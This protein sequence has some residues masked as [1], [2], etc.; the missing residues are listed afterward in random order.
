M[1]GLHRLRHRKKGWIEGLHRLGHTDELCQ[2]P[3]KNLQV[4]GRASYSETL[5][6][7]GKRWETSKEL[8]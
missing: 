3:G 2:E 8:G 6:G 4:P 5:T 7:A 1:E